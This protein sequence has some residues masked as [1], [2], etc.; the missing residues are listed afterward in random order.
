M[1]RRNYLDDP[2]LSDRV[3]DL[4]ETWFVGI[5][6]PRRVALRLGG[7]WDDCSTPFVHE[8]AGRIVSHVGLLEMPY[9]VHGKRVQLGGVHG[10]CTLESERRK[11]HFR[12]LMEELLAYCE[13][14]FETLVLSTEHPEY[15]EP[16][17]FR[18][19][20]EHRFVADVASSGGRK[21]F[22]P[23]DIDRADDLRRLDDLLERRTA[24]SNRVGI[25]QEQQ[26]FKFSQG[27]TGLHYS[28]ALDCFAVLDF[29]GRRLVLSDLVAREIPSLPQLLAEVE[30]PV[31]EVEFHFSPDRFDVAARPELYRWDTDFYMVRG[32]FAAEGEKFMV[33][34]SARH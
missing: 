28:E 19:V 2:K 22:R 20:P 16:F 9:V 31:D 33:P 3:F 7:R 14:R 13:P 34:P 15:Y 23:F 6:E 4:L 12:R 26:V 24:V 11:G 32:P 17:G 30:S 5:A 8:D 27:T 1:Y 10:V 18:V 29:Q 25:V 21:G